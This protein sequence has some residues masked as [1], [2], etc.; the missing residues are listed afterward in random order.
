MV[1]AALDTEDDVAVV[2]VLSTDI[3]LSASDMFS[4]CVVVVLGVVGG[5]DLFLPK[6]AA[7]YEDSRSAW[8]GVVKPDDMDAEVG[9]QD[10][11]CLVDWV[12]EREGGGG[13]A[14]EVFRGS[15]NIFDCWM[16]VW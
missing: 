15:Q 3:L 1:L 7:G 2:A 10:L 4:G 6:Y 8:R 13:E 16:L 5:E 14:E 12:D 11:G 9:K